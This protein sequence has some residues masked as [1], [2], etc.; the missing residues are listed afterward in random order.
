[1]RVE[2]PRGSIEAPAR[3]TGIRPGSGL[4]AVPLRLLGP[5]DEAPD[6]VP[7]AANELTITAWDPVSK[8]PIFK[9]AAVRSS[10]GQGELTMQLAHYLGLLHRAQTD[11]AAA[12]REVARRPRR[13]GRRASPLR[14]ARRSNA[15]RTPPQLEPFAERYGED[16]PRR[17]RPA[18]HASSS[19]AP[20]RAAWACCATCTTST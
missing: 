17:A 13:R 1:M 18:V 9:V 5:G 7:R 4:R 19:R 16:A 15:T 3:L 8:Q 11:L 14:A 20:A 6:G 10:E 2:S 12:F